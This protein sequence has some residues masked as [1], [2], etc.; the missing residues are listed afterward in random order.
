MNTIEYE[1]TSFLE[2]VKLLSNSRFTIKCYNT[3]ITHFEKFL[4]HKHNLTIEKARQ[5]FLNNELN[6]YKTLQEFVVHLNSNNIGGSAIRAYLSSTKG[7]MRHLGIKINSDD[8]R[9]L[10]KVPRIIKKR[11]I[12][13]TKTMISR[14]LHIS[15]PR[16]Q[17]AILVSVSGGMRLE[18]M[19]QLRISD[20][21]FETTPTT[22]TIRSEI[23]KRRV[24]RDTF[25][26][27]EA[28]QTLK[29]YLSIQF[30]WKENSTNL[31]LQNTFVFGRYSE[32][33]TTKG[34]FSIDSAKNTLQKHLRENANKVPELRV[35]NENG[36]YAIHF[37]GFRKYFRTTLG[38][39]CGRDYAEALMGHAFYMDTYYQLPEDKKQQMYLDAEPQLT[40]SDFETVEKN[41]KELSMKN[42]QLE[43]KFNDLLDY[44]KTNKIEI[45]NL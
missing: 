17:T 5:N 41:I 10:V 39:V 27:T 3:G 1:K 2:S 15:N 29:D 36:R 14:L 32:E 20:I 26:T 40:I 18:E 38:N 22:V 19:V 9:Q 23:A 4:Q 11:E 25:L 43:E 31:H 30:G 8:L 13:I 7:F 35:F 34:K 45:P 28:T 6:V 37:H 33:K 16:L 24:G 21:N 12:P 42:S 44:L